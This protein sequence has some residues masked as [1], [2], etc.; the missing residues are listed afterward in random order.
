MLPNCLRRSVPPTSTSVCT[1][2]LRLIKNAPQ[3]VFRAFSIQNMEDVSK[4][5]FRIGK[6]TRGTIGNPIS[7]YISKYSTREQPDVL[8]RLHEVIYVFMYRTSV[9]VSFCTYCIT[10]PMLSMTF[11][12]IFLAFCS[13]TRMLYALTHNAESQLN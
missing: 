12:A 6:S 7:E 10:V 8:R 4:Y 3:P 13:V 9:H 5:I 1:K 11:R 2:I